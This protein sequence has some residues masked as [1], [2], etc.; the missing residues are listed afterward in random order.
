[1]QLGQVLDEV[2]GQLLHEAAVAGLLGPAAL[3]A[4][5]SRR[6]A[7]AASDVEDEDRARRLESDDDAVQI[8]TIHRCEGLEFPAVYCPFLWRDSYFPRSGEGPVLFHDAANDDRLTLDVAMEGNRYV[9]HHHAAQL[10]QRGEDLRL[11]YVALTR[12]KMQAVLWWAASWDAHHSALGRLL[13]RDRDGNVP[14]FRREV[15]EDAA[16]VARLE[17]LAAGVPGAISI[18]RADPRPASTWTGHR[19]PARCGSE[20]A[21]STAAATAPGGAAPTAGSSPPPTSRGSG[22]SRRRP[23]SRTN[24]R[25][26]RRSRR[27]RRRGRRRRGAPAYRPEEHLGGVA[28]LFQRGMSGPATPLVAGEPC[29]V[30]PRQPPTRLIVAL[31]DL[32]DRGR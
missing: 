28:Y 24:R 20:C 27:S 15:P 11:A 18:E 17:R 32:L 31:S 12:A 9:I 7:E 19:P 16:A 4:W 30:L 23:A 10:E 29:G 3:I 26:V 13:F 1:V 5:L 22:A 2:V 14:A 21:S 8:L 6:I 25:R